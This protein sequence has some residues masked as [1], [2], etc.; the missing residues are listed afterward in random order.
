MTDKEIRE[1]LLEF[2]RE[3]KYEVSSIK[4]A[5]E[6]EKRLDEFCTENRVTFDQMEILNE[7]GAGEMLYMMTSARAE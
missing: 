2:S 4:E 5:H 1:K 7:T 6:L 3:I